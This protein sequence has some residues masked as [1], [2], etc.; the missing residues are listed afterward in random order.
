MWQNQWYDSKI[1]F[2][3][4]L[5]L[6]FNK[7]Y[8]LTSARAEHWTLHFTQQ[9][10]AIS[11]H[12]LPYSKIYLWSQLPLYLIH[13]CVCAHFKRHLKNQRFKRP[14]T[15]EHDFLFSQLKTSN[16]SNCFLW[17]VAEKHYTIYAIFLYAKQKLSN[18]NL[19]TSVLTIHI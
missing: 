1:T 10:W 16:P 2:E 4:G 14:G 15:E 8:P 7:A 19:I 17:P 18:R 3:L 12:F 5:K 6:S 9:C 11:L 13:I